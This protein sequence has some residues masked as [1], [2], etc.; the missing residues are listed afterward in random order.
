MGVGAN[1]YRIISNLYIGNRAVLTY[2][3]K[4]LLVCLILVVF[5]GLFVSMTGI[6]PRLAVG[7]GMGSIVVLVK[8]RD[9]V[10]RK[11]HLAERHIG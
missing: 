1:L 7:L 5:R 2:S 3:T 10:N 4:R 11:W 8:G 9:R 6:R